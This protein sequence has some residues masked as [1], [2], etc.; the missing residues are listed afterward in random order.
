MRQLHI[1]TRKRS[2]K[3]PRSDLS[4][5]LVVSER[6]GQKDSADILCSVAA[7][8]RPVDHSCILGKCQRPSQTHSQGAHCKLGPRPDD[9]THCMAMGLTA[10]HVCRNRDLDAHIVIRAALVERPDQ[11]KESPRHGMIPSLPPSVGI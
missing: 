6:S 2:D 11:S 4:P 5:A 1:R 9:S 7:I 8:T 3:P 10:V